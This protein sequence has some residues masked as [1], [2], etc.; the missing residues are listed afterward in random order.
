M[1]RHTKAFYYLLILITLLGLWL[2]LLNY[3]RLPPFGET[4]DEFFYPWAGISLLKT[5]IPTSW[6]P[7]GGY[8]SEQKVTFWGV[9]FRLVSPWLEKPPLYSLLTGG[10]SLLAYQDEFGEVRLLTIR[11]VPILLNTLAILLVGLLGAR[12]FDRAVG[13]IASTLYATIP[14][15]VLA[16]R[17]SLT[18]NL[19]IPVV[20]FT[21]WVY[22]ADKRRSWHPYAVGVGCAAALLTKQIGV[23]LPVGILV[24]E[25]YRKN[26]RSLIIIGGLTFLGG[27]IHPLMALY[28]NSWDLYVSLLRQYQDAHALGVPQGVANL[29][30]H[31]GIGH[32]EKIFVDGSMLVGYILL[33]SAPLWVLKNTNF[34]RSVFLAFP[35]GYLVLFTFLV[36]NRT[37]YGW[38]LFP[39]YPFLAL[40]LAKVFLDLWREPDLFRYLALFVVLGFSSARFLILLALPQYE[41]RWPT[42]MG[43][44]LGV[45][46]VA[47]IVKS[48]RF[49]L[50]RWLLGGLFVAYVFINIFT[51]ANLEKIY[52]AIPQPANS[53]DKPAIWEIGIQ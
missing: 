48:K 33:F 19:L 27:I 20:L 16:N 51:V 9:D 22:V 32:K 46:L 15:I 28:Y 29:F 2:R 14:T 10:L 50:H 36:G 6:S 47:W 34:K 38:H 53:H 24:L 35:L 18:E 12:L 52:S 3:D 17:L 26:Y 41:T 8:T 31:P 45:S 30:L 4:R 21:L 49:P 37:W 23:V 5:G 7:F 39:L 42:P 11:L 25:F 40:L 44:I 1:T 43:F 13:L